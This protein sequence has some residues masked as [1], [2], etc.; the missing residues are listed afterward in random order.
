MKSFKRF[1]TEMSMADAMQV[2]DVTPDIDLA[3]LKKQFRRKASQYHPDKGGSKEE[4][5]KVND[6]YETLKDNIGKMTK[7]L[8]RK[9]EREE[10]QRKSREV[11]GSVLTDMKMRFVHKAYIDHFERAFDE[12]FTSK[13]TSEKP[14]GKEKYGAPSAELNVEFVNSDRSIVFEVKISVSYGEVLRSEGKLAGDNV[15]YQMYVSTSGL[16][17]GKKKKI[18]RRDWTSTSKA[19]AF[20]IPESIF[21]MK[22]LKKKT[23]TKIF[24]KSDMISTLTKKLKAERSGSGKN[25]WYYLPLGED[26]TYL[27]IYRTVMLKQGMWSIHSIQTVDTTA[28]FP[29]KKE[30]KDPKHIVDF[31][32]LPEDRETLEV[33]EQVSKMKGSKAAKFLKDH[34]A[35]KKKEWGI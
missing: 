6:A 20:N 28:K 9:A 23:N 16:V 11:M 18:T 8:D 30:S 14:D 15:T 1:I 4:M 13:I 24:K 21:P 31:F 2:L 22:T 17:H 5:Q 26:N 33:F 29:R 32:S 7:A 25:I 3:G 19:S 34:Y 35:K 10:E 27:A 12:K